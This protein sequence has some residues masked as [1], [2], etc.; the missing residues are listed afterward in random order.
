VSVGKFLLLLCIILLGAGIRLHAAAHAPRFHPDEA[1]FATFARNA[2]VNGDWLLTGDLDKPPLAIYAQAAAMIFTAV[3]PMDNG[4]LNMDVYHGEFAAR[5][6]SLFAGILLIPVMVAITNLL[7]RDTDLS[8]WVGFLTAC[9]PMLIGFSAAAFLDMPALLLCALSLWMAIAQ[10]W[11]WALIWA[12]LAVFTKDS[13]VFM[14]IACLPLM[15]FAFRRRTRAVNP[16]ALIGVIAGAFVV[17]ALWSV[18]RGNAT[19]AITVLIGLRNNFNLALFT[20]T[21]EERLLVLLDYARGLF[22]AAS[23][24]FAVLIPLEWIASR[25]FRVREWQVDGAI[26][27]AILTVIFLFVLPN[28]Y[29]RYLLWLFPFGV[30]LAAISGRWFYRWMLRRLTIPE[31]RV[32]AAGVAIAFLMGAYSAGQR[33]FGYEQSTITSFSDHSGIDQVANWLNDQHV[34]AVVYDHWLNWQL[35]YYMGQW[36]DKRRVYYPSPQALVTDALAL[37]EREPRYFPIPRA[38][39]AG[40]W[41]AALRDAGFTV[42]VAHETPNALI[43][44][45]IPPSR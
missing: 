28:V 14:L 24:V 36:S 31:A 33:D 20:H 7:F 30:I 3:R 45:L 11:T 1:F 21:F 12:V 8:L 40:E 43:Y 9:S 26:L 34:A 35:G 32:A 19:S 22:G 13:A 29:D 5:L 10:R 16:I 23:A 37:N 2:A 27:G 17:A 4:V 6:P 38:Q 41:L 25:R 18:A 15:L 42:T 44:Q 39:V